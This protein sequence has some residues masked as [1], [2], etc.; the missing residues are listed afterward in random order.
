MYDSCCSLGPVFVTADSLADPYS[1]DISCS[2][3]R[4]GK[5]V[6]EGAVSTSKL[7]RRLDALVAALTFANRVPSGSVLLT[8]TGIIVPE[9]AL[10]P[11]DIVRIRVPEIGELVNTAA[12]VG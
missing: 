9:I 2:I 12:V 8:G 6:F 7:H 1:L 3:E 10:T 11:G 4:A 5:L